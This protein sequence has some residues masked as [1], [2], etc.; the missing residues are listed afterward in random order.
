[1]RPQGFGQVGANLEDLGW[2]DM[3]FEPPR[4]VLAEVSVEDSPLVT[5]PNPVTGLT[6]ASPVHA[7]QDE[8]AQRL[9]ISRQTVATRVFRTRGKLR[10]IFESGEYQQL[11]A[12]V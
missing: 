12:A 2:N 5:R 6:P 3:G 9:S 10:E 11:R 1:M 7:V 8:I 4:P